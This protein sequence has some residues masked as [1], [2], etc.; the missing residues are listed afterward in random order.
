MIYIPYQNGFGFFDDFTPAW[1]RQRSFSFTTSAFF[2]ILSFIGKGIKGYV[3]PRLKI[4][5]DTKFT[6][7]EEITRKQFFND[8]LQV[9]TAPEFNLELSYS[10]ILTTI[11]FALTY[12]FM[13]PLIFIFSFLQL[14][15]IFYIDKILCK[16]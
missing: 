2:R 15:V 4:Y 14:L 12:G 3:L 8:Y 5:Y 1:F 10:E 6:N 9:H 11:F 16:F 13:M 7:N